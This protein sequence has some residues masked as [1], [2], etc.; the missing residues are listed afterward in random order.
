MDSP[1][2]ARNVVK[3]YSYSPAVKL[4]SSLTPSGVIKKIPRQ[5]SAALAHEIRNPL[6]NINLA[7]EMLKFPGGEDNQKI[8]LDI[9][10]RSSIRIN[11]LINELLKYQQADEVQTEKHSMCGLLDEVLEMA[12]DRILLKNIKV[13]KD[14]AARDCKIVLNRSKIKI[15]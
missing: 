14:Y 13:M 3:V 11:D 12:K 15:A 10:M 1:T 6:S 5:F 9:I 8:Y 2:I 4:F 7:V